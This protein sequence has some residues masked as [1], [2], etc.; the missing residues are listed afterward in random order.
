[1]APP[2]A[3]SQRS[4]GSVF[5]IVNGRDTLCEAAG[6]K[7]CRTYLGCAGARA[8]SLTFACTSTFSAPTRTAAFSESRAASRPLVSQP[9]EMAEILPPFSI[10]KLLG[11]VFV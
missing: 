4:E 11:I 10:R 5:V 8:A 1:M 6:F 9:V 2:A 7:Q 3:I